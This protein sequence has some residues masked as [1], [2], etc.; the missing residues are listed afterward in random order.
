MNPHPLILLI[1]IGLMSSPLWSLRATV[2]LV[3]HAAVVEQ[4]HLILKPTTN[5]FFKTKLIMQ[6]ISNWSNNYSENNKWPSK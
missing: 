4:A 6:Y 5:R 3:W 1:L 2:F